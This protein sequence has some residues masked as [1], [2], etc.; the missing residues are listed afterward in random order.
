MS[1]GRARI[2]APCRPPGRPPSHPSHTACGTFVGSLRRRWKAWKGGALRVSAG[3]GEG[4]AAPPSRSLP[5]PAERPDRPGSPVP[6][7]ARR[8]PGAHARGPCSRRA[9]PPRRTRQGAPRGIPT[10]RLAGLGDSGRMAPPPR[11]RSPRTG[12]DP[13]AAAGR[14]EINDCD[15]RHEVTA[16]RN[17]G[18]Q[19]AEGRDREGK[20]PMSD[21]ARYI[22]KI[23]KHSPSPRTIR[24][25]RS[26]WRRLCRRNA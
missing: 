25:R 14:G 12:L 26:Q 23:R 18:P 7:E 3:R 6:A 4:A 2:A 10:N 24:A 5:A 8:L 9:S 11:R 22:E 13:T 21:K 15:A 1:S 19:G 17:R 20:R 16:H